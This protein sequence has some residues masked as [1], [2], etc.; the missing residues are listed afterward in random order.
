[1]QNL[2][3]RNLNNLFISYDLNSQGQ[4]CEKLVEVI[5]S[6][7]SCVKVHR[8]FWYVSSR[9]SCGEAADRVWAAMDPNDSLMV[10]DVTNMDGIWYNSS[11]DV[12]KHLQDRWFM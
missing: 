10:V 12:T 7:G 5:E 9:H 6:L 3:L 1:M 11:P 8:T 4:N 2:S